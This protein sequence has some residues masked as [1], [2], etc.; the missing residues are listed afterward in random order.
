VHLTL[1]ITDVQ[2]GAYSSWALFSYP[3]YQDSNAQ[4]YYAL[5]VT[6]TDELLPIV[7]TPVVGEFCQKYHKVFRPTPRSVQRTTAAES[8][9]LGFV[10]DVMC[11]DAGGA[12]CW[13]AGAC[14]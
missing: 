1:S 10:C 12:G 3:C 5:L 7:Y 6:F 13:P 4:L 8:S 14:T 2:F 11:C 9:R